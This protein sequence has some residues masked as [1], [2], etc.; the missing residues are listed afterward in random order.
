MILSPGS[1]KTRALRFL[2]L[3]VLTTVPAGFALKQSGTAP[4]ADSAVPEASV[5]GHMEFLAGDAMRG[6]GSGTHDELVA[7]TYIASE[8]RRYGLEPAGDNAGFVQAV[9]LVKNTV[10]APPVLS[11]ASDEAAG[12][13]TSW[14]HGKEMIVVAMASAR[15]SGP[16]QKLDATRDDST[17]AIKRGA[18]VL[19]RPSSKQ[20]APSAQN[21][22]ARIL[23]SG[24][25]VV[26]LPEAPQTRARWE[27]SGARFPRL[28]AQIQGVNEENSGSGFSLA[29][30]STE[31]FTQLASLPD[32]VEVTLSAEVKSS[33]RTFTWNAVG[34]LRGSDP[35]LSSEAILLTAHLDHL[36]VRED[37]G[38]D[39]IYN[40]ADDDASGVVAVLEL[41]RFLGAHS[42]PKRTVVFACF[43]SEEA[44]GFGAL[45]FQARPPV[46]LSSFVANLEFEMIARPDPSV[47][48]HTLWL[49]GYERSN[50][51]PELAARGAR[52]VADPHPAQNFFQRSD[53]YILA[54][55]GMIAQTVSSF[56]LHSDYHRPSDDLQHADFKHMTESINSM[57]E[58]VLWLVNSNFKP[59]WLP[60]MQP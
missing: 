8:F 45:F 26:L 6:R 24:A 1:L 18:V 17:Q 30:L 13:A 14:T 15:L 54:R 38:G 49:T 22:A 57:V 19:L 28:A 25:S 31:A 4:P 27:S 3:F 23:Q 41:A 52:I 36:G 59:H 60:G 55:K 44:G 39:T 12:R 43:G 50:L 46:P 11:F 53:N 51:G 10:T 42:R 33:P 5:R 37:A 40:G 29:V 9:E 7:A 21:Q 20:D 16:L 58:P 35:A 32:G 2:L 48:P 56:G 34:L 47:P